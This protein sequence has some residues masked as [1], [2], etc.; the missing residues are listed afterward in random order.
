MSFEKGSKNGSQ[1]IIL[2][3][4]WEQRSCFSLGLVLF[5]VFNATFTGFELTTVVVIGTDCMTAPYSSLCPSLHCTGISIFFKSTSTSLFTGSTLYQSL[6]N[7]HEYLIQHSL[8]SSGGTKDY[9]RRVKVPGTD[10]Y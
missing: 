2:V 1:D 3:A 10:P 6:S 9:F 8:K 4:W 5:I 7:F